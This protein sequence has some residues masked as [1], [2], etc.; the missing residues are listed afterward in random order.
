MKS[1]TVSSIRPLFVF[2]L[3]VSSCCRLARCFLFVLCSFTPSPS[4][5]VWPNQPAVTETPRRTWDTSST[6][7]ADCDTSR[8]HTSLFNSNPHRT[9]RCCVL[10]SLSGVVNVLTGFVSVGQMSGTRGPVGTSN[11]QESSLPFDLSVFKS[12]LQIEVTVSPSVSPPNTL[13]CTHVEFLPHSYHTQTSCLMWDNEHQ[14]IPHV[15]LSYQTVLTFSISD[16]SRVYGWE[17]WRS[18]LSDL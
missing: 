12:L 18:L 2:G 4:S 9:V 14:V 7:P 10:T 11:I 3:Q 5:Y 6:S 13:V 8:S 16:K 15:T 1:C 17:S